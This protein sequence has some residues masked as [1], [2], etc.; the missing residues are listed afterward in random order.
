MASEEGLRSRLFPVGPITAD[1]MEDGSSLSVGQEKLAGFGRCRMLSRCEPAPIL[2]CTLPAK[3]WHPWHP[4][5]PPSELSI[6][7]IQDIGG[8]SKKTAFGPK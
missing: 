5:H 4:W 3:A 6:S 7:A 8:Q 1:V 2:P